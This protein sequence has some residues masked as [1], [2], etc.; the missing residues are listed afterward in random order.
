ML[1]LTLRWI[2][3]GLVRHPAFWVAALGALAFVPL[4]TR[5]DPWADPARLAGAACLP[6]GLV[7][8]ALGLQRAG[9]QCNILARAPAGRRLAL[10]LAAIGLGAL[11]VQLPLLV[12]WAL[13]GDVPLAPRTLGE[14]VLRLVLG[15]LHLAAL[16][17]CALRFPLPD[18]WRPFLFATILWAAAGDW[19][20]GRVGTLLARVAP[21]LD[22]SR[23]ITP[24]VAFASAPFTA[25][26]AAG[27]IAGLLLAAR[28]LLAR[29]DARAGF[30]P[31]R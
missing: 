14:G 20:T 10:E 8:A 2:G 31:T 27:P 9:L 16:G 21:V 17:A 18:P 26:S 6:A 12:G 1:A 30:A 28:L 3:A 4:L 25:L 11:V 5:L 22:V 7:G 24:E 13:A 23:Q 15:D 19:A 29:A